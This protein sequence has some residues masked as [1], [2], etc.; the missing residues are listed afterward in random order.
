MARHKVITF[1]RLSHSRQITI[2]ERAVA[3][4]VPPP[5]RFADASTFGEYLRGHREQR[6][7]SVADVAHRTKLPVSRL[8]AL[9]RGDVARL[10]AGIYGRALV[11]AYASTI[12]LDP[13]EM[14]G[15]FEKLFPRPEL[16]LP[17]LEH[18]KPSAARRELPGWVGSLVAILVL[19]T[20]YAA[21]TQPPS[22]DSQ[23]RADV[24]HVLPPAQAEVAATTGERAPA[25]GIQ[26]VSNDPAPA[27]PSPP[28]VSVLHIASN[29][30]GARV[31]V[32]GIGWG[33]TPLTIRYLP[34]GAKIVRVSKDGYASV[35]TTV[36][37][38]RDGPASVSLNLE[39][40][41]SR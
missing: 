11:T 22:I 3:E 16:P 27:P 13:K 40:F 34:P 10:P 32:N 14:A 17:S 12:G 21:L 39:A 5:G 29:P 28:A 41:S 30:P 9:E 24:A 20:A 18:F 23:A 25:A 4:P 36:T 19:G 37:L 7:L 2:S 33:S 35:E 26:L 38:T 6:R 1:P 8:E 31:T 15:E